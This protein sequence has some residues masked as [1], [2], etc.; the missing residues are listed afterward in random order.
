MGEVYLVE[1]SSSGDLRAAKVMRYLDGAS[2]DDLAGFRQEAT[3]PLPCDFSMFGSRAGTR[4][5]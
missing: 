1:H 4:C 3:I 5:C 2:G